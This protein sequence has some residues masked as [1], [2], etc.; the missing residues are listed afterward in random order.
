VNQLQQSN[1]KICDINPKK[2]P[3][4]MNLSRQYLESIAL[5]AILGLA[6]TNAS[7][8]RRIETQGKYEPLNKNN[9]D[10]KASDENKFFLGNSANQAPKHDTPSSECKCSKLGWIF[11]LFKF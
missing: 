5:V 4:T 2:K 11:F 8:S 3:A 7:Y 6:V 1:S 10:V 9:V